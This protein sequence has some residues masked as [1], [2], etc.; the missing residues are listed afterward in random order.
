MGCGAV[1]PATATIVSRT[2]GHRTRRAGSSSARWSGPIVL[3]SIVRAF[4]SH[5]D[6]MGRL[7]SQ[8]ARQTAMKIACTVNAKH[9][10]AFM[11]CACLL[12][13]DVVEECRLYDNSPPFVF[14][15][16]CDCSRWHEPIGAPC[17]DQVLLRKLLEGIRRD[18]NLPQ[19]KGTAH[20]S[21]FQRAP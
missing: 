10:G 12:E 8:A 6:A 21:G 16:S 3:S 19:W 17:G 15:N 5:V 9:R 4:V 11:G 20:I 1:V 2:S 14:S 13:G 7:R 18:H